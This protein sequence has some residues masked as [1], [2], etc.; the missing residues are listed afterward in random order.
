MWRVPRV[1][2]ALWRRK[3]KTVRIGG[4]AVLLDLG[5][6]VAAEAVDQNHQRQRRTIW[7]AWLERR[8]QDV[9]AC[10]EG[11][12][13]GLPAR[14]R[15]SLKL[16]ADATHGEHRVRERARVRRRGARTSFS[17]GTA[18]GWTEASTAATVRVVAGNYG[19]KSRDV[20]GLQAHAT[21]ETALQQL[22]HALRAL[23]A[24]HVPYVGGPRAARGAL[25]AA[26]RRAGR[27]AGAARRRRLPGYVTS[28]RRVE[29]VVVS[30]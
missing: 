17:A 22:S 2:I 25:P 5:S 19:R 11:D 20:G 15:C 28:R 21:A 18:L 23:P 14:G 16:L 27:R 29:S 26:A 24:R 30:S 4:F 1:L 7:P 6:G 9:L 3:H 13:C 10:A 8:A 12:S